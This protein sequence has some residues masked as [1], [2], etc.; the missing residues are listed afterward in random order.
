[1]A[2]DTPREQDYGDV[3]AGASCLLSVMG[4]HFMVDIVDVSEEGIRV[5]FPGHD[6]PVEGM[7]VDLEFHD[8]E[9]FNH[10]RTRVTKGPAGKE[11]GILLRPTKAAGRTQHRDSCRV[12]T[13]LTVQVRDQV[14]VRRYD[15]ALRNLSAGGALLQTRAPFEFDTTLEMTLSLPG[16]P[17]HTILAQVLHTN[18]VPDSASEETLFGVRFVSVDPAVHR[19]LTRYIW[20]RLRELYS[21]E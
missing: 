2:A 21:G 15:A 7:V 5:T 20:K 10:Y 19:S 4:Q 11:H 12:P 18:V 1:M 9:G 6:Y 3:K 13:D 17:T 16:E 8:T 14:H